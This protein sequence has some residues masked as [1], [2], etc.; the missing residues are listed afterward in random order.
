MATL[1]LCKSQPQIE[2][3]VYA[4]CA[5]L[6]SKQV[7][8]LDD[9]AWLLSL[10][11][12]CILRNDVCQRRIIALQSLTAILQPFS[13]CIIHSAH[14]HTKQFHLFLSYKVAFP[15]IFSFVIKSMPILNK[16]SNIVLLE[17]C[18]TKCFYH[19]LE[20]RDEFYFCCRFIKKSYKKGHCVS[21]LSNTKAKNHVRLHRL[22]VNYK[23]I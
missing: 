23:I 17:N 19:V 6:C 18:L 20:K 13:M 15:T 10:M 3:L 21:K 14:T 16:K 2:S 9:M 11:V 22:V 1:K 12:F 4:V 7:T 8:H 5:I